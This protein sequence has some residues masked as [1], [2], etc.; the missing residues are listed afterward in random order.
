MGGGHD[1]LAYP[2]SSGPILA[3][4]QVGMLTSNPSATPEA[5]TDPHWVLGHPG[6]GHWR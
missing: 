1:A 4:R 3:Q 5:T 6:A 2:V